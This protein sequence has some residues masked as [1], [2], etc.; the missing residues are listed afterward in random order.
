MSLFFQMLKN[1]HYIEAI[2]NTTLNYIQ[3]Q[4]SHTSCNWYVAI[5]IELAK[6]VNNAIILKLLLYI[7]VF[8]VCLYNGI[9]GIH[10][11]YGH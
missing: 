11:T 7:S 1:Y 6:N 8:L 2:N 10:E 9:W 5:V 3:Y 4:A